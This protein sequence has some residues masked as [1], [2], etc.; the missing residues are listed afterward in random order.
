MES[1][2]SI[3]MAVLDGCNLVHDVGYL[4][5]GLAGSAAAVVM[6][7]EIISYARRFGRGFDISKD[8][9]GLDVIHE[10]GPGGNFLAHEHTLKYL[11]EEHW[12]PKLLNRQSPEIWQQESG[13][14]Y[15]EVVVEKTLEILATHAPGRL[16]GEAVQRL[17]SILEKAAEELAD[18]RSAV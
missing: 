17:D 16:P 9:I 4:G 1:M 15:G 6:C 7:S 11:R 8:R 12:A 14:R 2:A 13:K 10:V 18:E 3:M 5:Q